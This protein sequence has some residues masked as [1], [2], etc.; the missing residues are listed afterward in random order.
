MNEV[1]DVQFLGKLLKYRA[2]SIRIH[3]VS[4]LAFYVSLIYTFFV[5]LYTCTSSTQPSPRSSHYPVTR[6]PCRSGPGAKTAR[7]VLRLGARPAMA[8]RIQVVHRASSQRGVTNSRSSRSTARSSARPLA[9]PR[10]GRSGEG[11]ATP[12]EA[13]TKRCDQVPRG[14]G[15]GQWL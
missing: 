10:P 8:R 14:D 5:L 3:H 6:E 1:R 13:Q 11:V 2:N 15:L 12:E 7:L 4:F 9:V